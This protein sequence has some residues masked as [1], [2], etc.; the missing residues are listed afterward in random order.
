MA[1]SSSGRQPCLCSH[2]KLHKPH[3][4]RHLSSCC[5]AAVHLKN[6]AYLPVQYFGTAEVSGVNPAAGKLLSYWHLHRNHRAVAADSTAGHFWR[7]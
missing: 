7:C 3:T 5:R 2:R 4:F 1:L 6:P